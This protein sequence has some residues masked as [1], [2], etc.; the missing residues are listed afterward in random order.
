MIPSETEIHYFLEI[1]QTLHISKAALRLG[2]TQPTLT[3]SLQKLEE[4]LDTK[5]FYRTKQGVVP[6]SSATV[7]YGQAQR[8]KECWKEIQEKVFVSTSEVEGV[9]TV[10]CHQSVAQYTAPSLLRNLQREA[11]KLRIHFLHDSSR[12]ITEK[13]VSYEVD[14]GYV[15]NPTKHLDLV[16]KKLGDDRVTFWQKKGATALPKRIFADG[17]REQVEELLGKTYQKHFREWKIVQSTSLEVVRTLVSQGLGIGI[18][19]ERVARA[20]NR[21]LEIYDRNLPFRHDEI[22]LAYRREVLSSKAGKELIRLAS[23]PLD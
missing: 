9:F 5:L 13:V 3:Q 10:G 15:V 17:Q 22:F 18:L 7:F 12:R 4:K 2:I 1:Y 23:F 16:L 20:E 8:L 6:T 19:P 21:N 14:I 11:P